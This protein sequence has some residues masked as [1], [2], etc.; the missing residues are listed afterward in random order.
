MQTC[1]DTVLRSHVSRCQQSAS[2][3]SKQGNN[4]A[5]YDSSSTENAALC[6]Y[7][8]QFVALLYVV[9]SRTAR[10]VN[11]YSIV[12][13]PD[14]VRHSLGNAQSNYI[15]GQFEPGNYLQFAL[16]NGVTS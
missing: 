4:Q 16:E 2:V 3:T 9:K 13:V 11:N 7:A 1:T 12:R 10:H 14:A 8:V 6:L 15:P 5:R